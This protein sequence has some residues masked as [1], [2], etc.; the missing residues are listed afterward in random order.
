MKG[1]QYYDYIGNPNSKSNSNWLNKP[2]SKWLEKS[3][4]L[5]YKTLDS[6]NQ[7]TIL[8]NIINYRYLKYN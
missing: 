3:Q 6:R 5:N 1:V 2:S 4:L 8:I 7:I